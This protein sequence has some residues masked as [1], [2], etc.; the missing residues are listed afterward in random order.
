MNRKILL[1]LLLVSANSAADGLQTISRVSA[2]LDRELPE[3]VRNDFQDDNGKPMKSVSVDLNN[4]KTPEKLIPNEFLCGNSS[5]PWLVYS[6]QLNRVIGRLDGNRVV[7]LDAS[8]EGYKSIRTHWSLGV[9]ENGTAL[10]K[11]YNGAYERQK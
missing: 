3:S 8:T 7:I 4:D 6:A 5:C 1:A 2:V 11:F 10:Y 9:G